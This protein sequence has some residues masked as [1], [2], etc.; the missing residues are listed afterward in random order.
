MASKRLVRGLIGLGLALLPLL[1]LLPMA[2]VSYAT[3]PVDQWQRHIIDSDR[4]WQAVFIDGGDVNGDGLPDIITGGW[5][6]QNPGS[7]GGAWPR[8]EIGGELYNMALVY[9]WDGD[10]D[11]DILGTKG[12]VASAEFVWA[13]NDGHGA[14]TLHNNV[15]AGQG[16]FLQGVRAAQIVPGGNVEVV[17]SWHD[18]SST[19]MFGIP[20]PATDPWSWEEISPTSN[21][22]QIGVDDIDGDGDLD[23][24]LGTQWLR[25]D[26][27]TWT[28]IDAFTMGD[29]AAEP[30]R[31]E[32]ADI[33]GDQD[34]DVV[35]GAEGADR[36]VWAEAPADPEGA[37]I[38]HVISTDILG[39]SLDVGDVDQDGDV[40][41]VVG[42]HRTNGRVIIFQNEGNGSS[43]NPVQ[44]DPVGTDSGLEH[45]DGTQFVDIDNDGDLDILSI[46]WGHSQVVLYENTA[47]PPPPTPKPTDTPPEWVHLSSKNG[48]LPVPDIGSQQTSALVLDVDQDGLNDFVISSKAAAPS[49]VWYRLSVTDNTPTWTQYLIEGEPLFLEAGGAFSDIDGDGYLD[50]VMGLD[51]AGPELWWWENPYPSYDTD[52]P[53]MRR[54]IKNT[55]G[56]KHHDQIF[57]DFD[58]DGQQELVFWNQFAKK[59]FIAEIPDPWTTEPWSYAEIYSWS[60]DIEHEGLAKADINGDGKVDVVGAGL[61]FEHNVGTSYT[62]H[63]IDASQTYTRV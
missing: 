23:I 41:V 13:E 1:G 59:L 3:L 58:G 39:M 2:Q 47:D 57:G 36:V 21:G 5:W 53:W 7:P 11:L 63:I 56:K 4:P 24:H 51:G 31:L 48:D 62:P 61:W 52:T 16:D 19:Q 44:I 50:V 49:M 10:E 25:N 33:D 55:G 30:D 29:P 37:W 6:Y 54:E 20:S 17:L 45:H 43:W 22:E 42:E 26:E 14:F 32:L 46:G 27:G 35:I 40:D 9:D 38:E 60:S 15:P 8:H 12:K 28:T 34:L 18:F